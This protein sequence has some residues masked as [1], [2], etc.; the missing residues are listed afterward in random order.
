ML[1]E[2]IGTLQQGNA[3][4]AGVVVQ[5]AIQGA[6]GEHAGEGQLAL[7]AP[8][9]VLVHSPMQQAASCS[10]QVQPDECRLS[11]SLDIRYDRS[12]ED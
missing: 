1:L 11:A 7:W 2:P 12:P 8:G 10:R 6:E 4:S 9:L 3:L 5:L